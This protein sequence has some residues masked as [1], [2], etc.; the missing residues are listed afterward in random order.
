MGEVHW[1]CLA[2][3]VW[4]KSDWPTLL[5]SALSAR[6]AMAVGTAG[7]T[8]MLCIMA[9][10]RH[11]L[12]PHD[13]PVLVTGAVGGVGS[14]AVMFLKKLGFHVVASTGRTE[15]SDY[16]HALGASDILD[17]KEL[18]E[19]GKPLQPERW[20]AVIDCVGSVTLAN[21]C[22]STRYGGVVAACGLAQGMD[23]PATVAPFILRGVTLAGIDSVRAPQSVRREAWARI[24]RLVDHDML[25]QV[26]R[27]IDIE[28]VIG[29]SEMLLAGKVRG[30]LVVRIAP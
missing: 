13:G 29:A 12:D 30:R 5:P 1:G 25:D 20:A 18:S 11:G 3:K 6:D 22:A 28:E 9:M 27:E 21:A 4:I 24:A 10:E 15:E 14:F 23:L 19:P 17:R 16:L 26:T 8:A 2:E 7:L